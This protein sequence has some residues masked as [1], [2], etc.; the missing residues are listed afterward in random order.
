[1]ANK[2]RREK[3]TFKTIFLAMTHPKRQ[4]CCFL[5][6]K[7]NIHTVSLFLFQHTHTHTH[8]QIHTHTHLHLSYSFKEKQ[9]T[10]FYLAFDHFSLE[11][12]KTC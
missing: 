3:A 7:L 11:K 5:V 6:K 12:Q 10:W 8:T 9:L 4:P 2:T 1:M